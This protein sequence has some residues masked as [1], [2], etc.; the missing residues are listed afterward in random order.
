[1]LASSR[2]NTQRSF[3]VTEL[4]CGDSC[5]R[6]GLWSVER[7]EC[8]GRVQLHKIISIMIT[9][10]KEIQLLSWNFEINYSYRI[11]FQLRIQI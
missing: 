6:V 4:T 3:K 5:A 10:Q 11:K 2:R 7:G 8:E 9:V 1:M